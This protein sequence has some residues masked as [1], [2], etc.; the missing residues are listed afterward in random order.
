MKQSFYIC[1]TCGNI[2][3]KVKDSGVPVMCCGKKMEEIIPGTSDVAVEKHVPVYTVENNIVSVTAGSAEHPMLP[4]HYI[5]WI[6][7]QTKQGNQ[8]KELKPG[9]PPKA[10][11]ALCEG[12]SVEAVYAYCNLHSLWKA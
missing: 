12:D 3:A 10:C 4:E 2:I 5:E 9:E 8:R 1:N 6:S 11:F 7:V